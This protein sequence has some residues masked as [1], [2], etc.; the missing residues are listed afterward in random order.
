MRGAGP[1]KP[2]SS[3]I[4]LGRR[5]QNRALLARQLLLRRAGISAAEALEHLVGMQSQ[6]ADPP[7]LGLWSR[8]AG[9]RLE[10]LSELVTA[11]R[12]VRV[13]LMRSTVHLVTARDCLAIRPLLQ[14][15]VE[16]AY[17]STHGKRIGGLDPRVVA[18]AGRALVEEA[19]RTFA[20]LGQCLSARFPAGEPEALAQTVRALVPLVQVPPRGLWGQSGAAAHTS[21]EAWLGR[22]LATG[23]IDDLVIRYLRAFGPAT[24]KDVQTWCGLT[25]LAEVIER[26]RP[27]LVTFHDEHG[28]VLFDLPDAPRPDP[29]TDAPIRFVTAFDN[30]LLSHDD[31]TRILGD[32]SPKRIMTVNGIVRATLLIDG[33]VHGTWKIEEERAEAALIVSPFRPIPKRVRAELTEEGERL[34]A[35]AAAGASKRA[36]RFETPA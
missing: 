34:L 6:A 14:P 27:R 16:R 10:D 20:E 8:V 12:A 13:A 19:P 22:A 35:F 9:F 15:M 36:I 29:D 21:A 33:F 31:R 28:N 24:V 5:A 26:L 17:K 7:Y 4:V 3:A 18:E 23:S 30:L 1:S 11:R 2:P 25:R 32:V